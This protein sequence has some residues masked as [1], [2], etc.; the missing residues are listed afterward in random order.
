MQ[1]SKYNSEKITVLNTVL[2]LLVLYIHSYYTEG[3]QY[4]VAYFIQR[5]MGATG[6]CSVANRIFF[7]LSGLLF[8]NNMSSVYDCIPKIKKRVRTILIPYI[9]WNC[10]FVLW[11]VILENIPGIETYVNSDVFSS[12][13]N[14]QEGLDY[15][16]I[17]PASFPLW[18]LRDLM[19]WIVCSP[20]LYLLIKYLRWFSL[21]VIYIISDY[22][23]AYGAFYFVLGGCISLLSTLESIDNVLNKYVVA[24]SSM[25]FVGFSVFIA[26]QPFTDLHLEIGF[27][28]FVICIC[29]LVCMWKWY[30]YI[31]NGRNLLE[32][33]FFKVVCGYS[34][35]IYLFHEPAFNIVKKLGL[36][37]FYV[38]EYSLIL[39]FLINPIIMCAISITTAKV[40]LRFV[41]KVYSILVGGR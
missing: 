3:E 41:P 37:I 27:G 20:I 30:D 5:F 26:V 10:I 39:L 34:F 19:L 38:H 17:S 23:P 25:A 24:L 29:S 7:V 28:G 6:I 22:L 9:L 31:A 2:I 13:S 1:I 15:L 35:F 12:F 18:F 8:F 32:L 36:K 14:L 11:Y 21:P 16:F 33:K 4:P 40:L